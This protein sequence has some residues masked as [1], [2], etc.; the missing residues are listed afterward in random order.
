[1]HTARGAVGI[2]GEYGVPVDQSAVACAQIESADVHRAEDGREEDEEGS[3]GCTRICNAAPIIRSREWSRGRST[4]NDDEACHMS[5]VTHRASRGHEI[6]QLRLFARSR[7]LASSSAHRR[8]GERV[9]M[10]PGTPTEIII[11]RR[12]ACFMYQHHSRERGVMFLR[13]P[14]APGSIKLTPPSHTFKFSRTSTIVQS[15]AQRHLLHPL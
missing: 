11:V 4:A 7:I 1:M 5:H 9:K 14:Q 10:N 8:P 2:V 13:Q 15:H 6:P 12:K 3:F